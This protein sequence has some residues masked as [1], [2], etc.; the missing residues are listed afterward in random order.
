MEKTFYTEK[1]RRRAKL[2]FN[3]ASGLTNR[4]PVQLMDILTELQQWKLNP[5]VSILEK[6]TDLSAIIGDALDRGITLFIACGGD[7]TVSA[8]AKELS[9][10]RATLGI[11]PTGT[12]NNIAFGLDL[13]ADIAGAAAV[14]RTGRR[15]RADLGLVLYNGVETPFLEICSV[16][17]MSSL[18]SSGDDIQHGHLERIGDFLAKFAASAPSKITM[19][20][21]GRSEISTMGYLVLICNMAYVGRHYQVGDAKSCRDGV[22]DVYLFRDLTKLD[23]MGCL[24]KK[25]DF[26]TSRN[27][28]IQHF[29]VHSVTI[30]AAPP[31]TVMADGVKFGDGPIEIKVLH[32]NLGVMVPAVKEQ[33]TEGGDGKQQ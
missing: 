16:G 24:I 22:L 31:M 26:R 6:D 5:E 20:L 30:E 15:V 23:M 2:I 27:A 19:L 28:H 21:D 25:T 11:I 9:G 4:S 18:F 7:G 3:P 8:V 32:R 1:R 29:R 13:P 14:L 33:P 12:Q 10:K 17:L